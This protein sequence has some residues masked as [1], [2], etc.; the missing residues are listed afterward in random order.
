MSNRRKAIE[1]S[2]DSAPAILTVE[3]AAALVRVPRNGMYDA[4]RLGLVPSA[5]FGSRRTRISKAEL[6]KVF[7]PGVEIASL[8]AA[9]SPSEAKRK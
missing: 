4:V 3:E 7:A 6:A 1:L 5:N 2:W 9:F 8:T